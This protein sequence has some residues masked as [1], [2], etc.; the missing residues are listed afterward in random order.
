VKDVAAHLLD[1][2][3][4]ALS[5]WRDR[6]YG[7]D[8]PGDLSSYEKL[9]GFLNRLNS[10]WTQAARRMSPAV[11]IHLLEFTSAEVLAF[12]A[13][14]DLYAPAPFPVAW[15]GEDESATWFHLARELT[16]RWHH[17]QQ[18]R[19][20]TGRENQ[21]ER[22]N[23]AELYL[24]V[25]DMFMQALPHHYR[26][27]AASEGATVEVEV[28]GEA[29]GVWTVER[30]ALGWRLV[31]DRRPSPAAKVILPDT[32]AWRIFTKGITPEEAGKAAVVIGDPILGNHVLKMVAVMA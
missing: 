24:P 21:S 30:Q 9:V 13:T 8:D 27:L 17:Q 31:A 20:A 4:R 6:Y 15:A 12:L 19:V 23:T 18:I 2:H 16:E 26:S 25:L 29:L 3:L 32:I 11:L 1:G 5:L 14:L 22:I 7:E 28:S 10:D